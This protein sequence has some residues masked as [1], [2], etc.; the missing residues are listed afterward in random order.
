[1]KTVFIFLFALCFLGCAKDGSNGAAGMTISSIWK[2]EDTNGCTPSE[3]FG[4]APQSCLYSIEVVK[5]TD[6]SYW[7]G[8]VA[9]NA[10]SNN[11]LEYDYYLKSGTTTFTKKFYGDGGTSLIFVGDVSANPPTFT[12]NADNNMNPSDTTAKSFTL[13]A[14]P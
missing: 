13:V 8:V 1:M 4:D 12:A 6:G 2:Y 10:N 14:L 9:F 11:S 5:F 7:T 3:S